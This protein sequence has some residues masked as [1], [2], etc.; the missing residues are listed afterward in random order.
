M[1]HGVQYGTPSQ[2]C[3]ESMRWLSESTA[4][5][6]EDYVYQLVDREHVYA[7]SYLSTPNLSID[8]DNGDNSSLRNYG[9]Y[10]FFQYLTRFRGTSPTV[11][12]QI[13]AAT[14]SADQLHALESALRGAGADLDQSWPEFAAYAWNLEAPYDKFDKQDRMTKTPTVAPPRA[15]SLG[16]PSSFYEVKNKSDLRLPHLSI[17]YYPFEFPDNTAS[18]IAIYNGI[19]RK[20]DLVTA[21]DYGDV[22]SSR[23]LSGG[24]T[25]KG[26]HLTVLVKID[27][28]W[29]K[30]E[31]TD[32]P[33]A[34]Y[35]RDV[36]AERLE[37]LMVIVSNSAVDEPTEVYPHGEY[38]P[39]VFASR[40]GCGAW[41]GD[42]D[43]TYRWGDAVVEKM[44]VASFRLE[45]M[46][47]GF[48]DEYTPL[49]RAYTPVSGGFAW[50]VSGSNGSCSYSGALGGSVTGGL[51]AF[52]LL[53]WVAGGVGYRGIVADMFWPWLQIQSVMTETCPPPSTTHTIPWNAPSF[54]L[55]AIPELTFAR[56]SP[57]GRTMTIDT[58]KAPSQQGH[59]G[60][61]HFR[62]IREP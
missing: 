58:S 26:A 46:I 62:A 36:K 44:K 43:L 57:D 48:Y 10:L 61:W 3:I 9:G 55:A 17:R 24:A 42:A 32:V 19:S 4:S 20:L 51:S 53:P 45:P 60:T 2:S 25:A 12:R 5:W 59:S 33:G 37:E 28:Q 14:A 1:F 56:V 52:H 54:V 16:I 50:S 41:E 22:F 23:P 34:T 49:F 7:A 47:D 39:L 11:V 27:G 29:K 21:E 31:L 15:V 6:F 40:T 8:S 35:C 18:S 30:E 13:W 38:S